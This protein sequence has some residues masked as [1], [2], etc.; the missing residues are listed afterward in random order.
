MIAQACLQPRDCPCNEHPSH[1]TNITWHASCTAAI[2][3]DSAPL[4]KG[5][6]VPLTSALPDL[7]RYIAK[8]LG[9]TPPHLACDPSVQALDYSGLSGCRG[10]RSISVL[11]NLR[12]LNLSD[13]AITDHSTCSL[14]RMTKLEYL[15]L[16]HSGVSLT[17]S[18]NRQ[19]SAP[20]RSHQHHE[21]PM[22]FMLPNLIRRF[23]RLPVVRSIAACCRRGRPRAG[24]HSAPGD[25]EGALHR[26]PPVHGPGPQSHLDADGAALPGRVWRAHIRRRLRPLQA[27][28]SGS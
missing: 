12:H 10:L 7:W 9:G 24:R 21:M 25:A 18:L 17:I 26:Q 20:W 15:N 2:N 13:T 5:M 6:C 23:G 11:T 3:A 19:P 14:S 22:V 8:K 1:V 16:S 4:D 27:R 28:L